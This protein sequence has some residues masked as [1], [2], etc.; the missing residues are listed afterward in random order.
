M[1]DAGIPK[2][3]MELDPY[4]QFIFK[5][6]YARWMEEE[7]R[8][9]DWEET[10]DRYLM[11]FE[12]RFPKIVKPMYQELYEAIYFHEVMP[13]M[14]ALMTA[15]REPGTGALSRDN[16]AGYNCSYLPVDSL[17][18]FDETLYL[19][20]NGVGVGF[21][22]ERQYISELPAVAGEFYESDI[23][24]KVA[25][26]KIGWSKAL[27]ETIALVFSGQIPSW[28]FSNVRPAGAILKTFGGRA[29]GPAPLE[30]MLK[31]VTKVIKGAAGRRLTSLECH[32]VQCM[33]AK[34]VI[35]GGV[36]RSAMI[37]LSNLSDQRMAG[38]KSGQW[39]QMDGQRSLSNNSVCYTEMPDVSAW[40]TEWKNIYE[41]KSGERGIF[42]RQAAQ[43]MVPER[44]DP[45]HEFG[46]NPCSEIVLRPRG[47]C[48]LSEVV[49]R[50]R[51]KHADLARKVRIASILGT[52]Q[53]TLTD[54]RYLS[55]AWTKVAEEERLLGVSF[56][57]IYDNQWLRDA[58]A[59]QLGVLKGI[60][61]DVN[62]EFAAKIGINQAA[63]VTCVK[64]SGSVSQF[65]DSSS[66]I[67]P[68]YGKHYWRRVRND[69]KDPISDVMIEAG[70][71]YVTDPYN[72]ES[73]S[74]KFPKVSPKGAV[75]N[76]DISAIEHLE[77]WKKFGIGWCEHKPSV[78]IS[79]A[80]EEWV[81]VGAW[82]YNNFNILSGVSFLPK[83]DSSHTYMEAPY[84]LCEAKDIKTYPRVAAIDWDN[85]NQSQDQH[86]EFACSA[87]ECEI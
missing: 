55:S 38:A 77:M 86:V 19:L 54:F 84:E 43:E 87:G 24:I 63:A 75:V 28:D 61:V 81:E 53:A 22:V 58:S 82:C 46:V 65:V 29:S 31:S 3:V 50:P 18:S 48:N 14:R 8:R 21:S 41:S 32:D 79:V 2:R 5:S 37:S 36:R 85:V 13:S 45:D 52:L 59:N 33:I 26:S 30:E 34:C 74:F 69:K 16:V 47:L 76:A 1:T 70:I 6:R 56:T 67:H 44:R 12:D 62:K 17:R 4:Q 71:P 15:D 64:P 80:E 9:E 25:D 78:T 39:W 42:N 11:F 83:E 27:K 73:W 60:A 72:S 57:G 23:V 68:R 7:G 20:M 10:V 66:G 35:V 49:V 51:D 40:M